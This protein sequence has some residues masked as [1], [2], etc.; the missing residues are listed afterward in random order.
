MKI[1]LADMKYLVSY[2]EYLT[3]CFSHGLQKYQA[4]ALEPK[5]YLESIIAHEQGQNLPNN[6][7]ETASYFCLINDEVVGTIRYRRGN[8]PLIEKVIGHTGYDTK[9]SARGKG[10]AKF[11]LSWLQEQVLTKHIIVTCEHS[12]IAS[13]K[14]IEGC[15]GKFINQ[16]YSSE[17]SAQVLRFKLPPNRA[18]QS[19]DQLASKP[20]INNTN[21]LTI[22]N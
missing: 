19:S 4:A 12:N 9:P 15:G 3:E 11:M 22:M 2:Q 1:F 6:T 8:S 16:I 7:P 17:K 14:V 21:Q 18:F 13:K 10:V 5:S 20:D